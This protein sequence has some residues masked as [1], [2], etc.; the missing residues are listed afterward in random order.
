MA[1]AYD[2]TITKGETFEHVLRWE[3]S[4]YLYKPITGITKAAPAVVTAATHGVPDGWRV[5]IVSVVGMTEINAAHSPP[6]AADFHKATVLTAST[7]ELNDVNS[8]EFTTYVSGGYVQY[9]TP[10]SLSGYTARMQVRNRAGGTLLAS[11][12]VDDTPLDVITVAV[13]DA[14]KTITVS[15]TATNT[16]A[17][18]W[19]R[20]VYDIEMV[21]GT[22]VVTALFAGSVAIVEEVT[23]AV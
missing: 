17:I 10:V 14:L 11:T 22:G 3:S 4:P 2:L 16:A 23:T 6:R 20:G 21:S 13:D 1:A 9:L 7:I 15:I 18:T 8:S 12:D 19:K 5:A